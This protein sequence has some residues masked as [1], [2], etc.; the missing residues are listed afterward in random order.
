MNA[1]FAVDSY[2]QVHR[3]ANVEVA[4]PHKLIDMLYEGALERIAQAKGAIQYQNIELRGKKIN[5]AIAIVGGLRSNLNHDEGGDI[6]ANL[7]AL[8]V[9]IQSIL[10]KA[11]R[12]A[13]AELLDEAAS[14]LANMRDAWQQIG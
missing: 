12:E 6:S 14:L 2:A 1:Q 9:Y 5:S 7:E 10:V 8:Y 3:N 13:N 4:S 11:H